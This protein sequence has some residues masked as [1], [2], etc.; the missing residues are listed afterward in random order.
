[1]HHRHLVTQEAPHGLGRNR[2]AGS[3]A[4][5]EWMGYDG[6]GG[7]GLSHLTLANRGEVV[8][9]SRGGHIA[10][11]CYIFIDWGT[12]DAVDQC[13]FDFSDCTGDDICLI[14]Y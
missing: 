4:V 5:R 14:D 7:E 9:A 11:L 12:C 6:K 13:G 2:R 1:M 10:A 8:T 3:G